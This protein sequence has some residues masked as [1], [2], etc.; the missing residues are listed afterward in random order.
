[1]NILELQ[2]FVETE[3]ME[4]P[5]LSVDESARCPVCGFISG[6][7][8]CPVC[9]A[10]PGRVETHQDP[11]SDERAHL[12]KVFAAVEDDAFDPFRTVAAVADLRDHLKQQ[13]RV[14]L[15]G[16]HLR[17]AE[18]IIDCLDEDGYFREPLYDTAEAFAASVPE[19]EDV[20]ALVQTFDPPG[21]AAKDLRECLLIQLSALGIENDA[22]LTAARILGDHWEGFSRMRLKAIASRLGIGLEEVRE[23]C[24]FIRENLNPRPASLYRPAFGRLAPRETAAV[25]PDVVVRRSGDALMADVVDSHTRHLG[26]EE[27]YE[28]AYQALRTGEANLCDD[29]RRHIREHVE[30][31]K[32]ILDA[33]QLRKKTL[34]RVAIE[35]TKCQKAFLLH[36]PSHL[37]PLRQKDLAK[38]LQVHES[39]ICRAVAG[40]YCKLPSGEVV[41]F[42]VFFDAALP[43]RTMISQLIARSAEPLSDGEIAR[44]LAE[45]G[46]T[47]ARRTVAKYREQMRLLPYQLRAA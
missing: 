19:V 27:T 40:K 46:V 8:A 24:E 3:A 17:I 47:I 22:A 15:G 29:D 21:V 41:S 31:V 37:K 35:L 25:V 38:K 28:R 32:C 18:Y 9:G 42:E 26:I 23:A 4:N 16:R 1:M 11:P 14:A 7:A 44:R 34:A 43:V 6:A 12:E 20:L 39:T 2:E 5:A 36:G 33:I 13:A 45:Q 30:R 10:A